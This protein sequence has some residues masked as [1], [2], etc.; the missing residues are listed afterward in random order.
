MPQE[1]KWNIPNLLSLYRLVSFPWLIYVIY[2]WQEK[3]FLVLLCINIA[4][5]ILDGLIARAFHLQTKLGARLDSAADWATYAAAGYG[6]VQF[7]WS[8]ITAQSVFLLCFL[9]FF[10]LPYILSYARFRKFPSLHLY[11]S[12]IGGTI[13]M[14]F[15]LYLF[16]FGYSHL[17]FLL[18]FSWGIASFLE[19]VIVL[20]LLKELKEDCKG[21]YWVLKEAS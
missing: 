18:A 9:G 10:L 12:K 16:L 8:F 4:T 15:L 14:I 17:L 19:Q 20:L 3:M 21:L 1:N 6:L 2:S 13:D 11:S 7:H 5:D